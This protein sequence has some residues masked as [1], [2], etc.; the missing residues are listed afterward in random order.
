MNKI[1]GY[2]ITLIPLSENGFDI[3]VNQSNI[4]IGEVCIKPNNNT[5]L[6]ICEVN[7]EQYDENYY[8]MSVC[9]LIKYALSALQN[10]SILLLPNNYAEF[11]M[12]KKLL[13]EEKEID[14]KLCFEWQNSPL[15]LG[16]YIHFKGNHYNL[17]FIA[18]HSEDLSEY[19]VYEPLY[20]DGGMWVRP[21]KMWGE[22]VEKENVFY[23]RFEKIWE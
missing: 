15:L 6:L 13:G 21:A 18:K 5:P 3:L 10:K 4:K 23:P 2:K 22:A 19:C 20:G 16:E 8:L 7:L 14:D 1:K 12:C 11:K 17:H 9:L